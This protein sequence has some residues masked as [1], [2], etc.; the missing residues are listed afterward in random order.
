MIH[1]GFGKRRGSGGFEPP[2][3]LRFVDL[4]MIIVTALMFTTVILSIISAFVGG[5]NVDVVPRVLTRGVPKALTNDSYELTLAATGG[6]GSYT[7]EIVEGQLPEGL[8][9]W[10]KEGI[11]V[12]I[13]KQIQRT[14]FVVKVSDSRGRNDSAKLEIEVDTKGEARQPTISPLHVVAP[15]VLLPDA[16]GEQPYKAVLAADGGIPPYRWRLVEGQ[17]P[18]GLFLSEEG[19]LTGTPTEWGQTK[20]FTV[21][22]IDAIGRNTMQMLKLWINPPPLPLWRTMLN[23]ALWVFWILYFLWLGRFYW[24]GGQLE[25]PGFQEI[26]RSWRNR[27]RYR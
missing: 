23:W 13:P 27:R 21:T 10:P 17:V 24:K 19:T 2:I 8:Q 4:F 20:V 5:V 12:G 18:T 1:S 25:F 6:S 11:I 14:Q 26:L 7:W 3:E 9:L 16:V 15:T 22:V